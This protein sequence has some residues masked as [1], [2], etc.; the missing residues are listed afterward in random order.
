[1][2]LPKASGTSAHSGRP[3]HG[4]VPAIRGTRD[5]PWE[6][7]G[8][9]LGAACRRVRRLTDDQVNTKSVARIDRRAV[10]VVVTAVGRV[11]VSK[12]LEP[13]ASEHR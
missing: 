1:M 2:T 3:I 12:Q 6:R 10:A 7:S 5:G 13:I 9:A 4:A 11:L 8:V